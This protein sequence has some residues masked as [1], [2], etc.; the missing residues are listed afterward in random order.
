MS[1]IEFIKQF[2]NHK[3]EFTNVTLEWFWEEE[4]ID[5]EYCF[6][7]NPVEFMA[8]Y[9]RDYDCLKNI[10]IF[11]V[12]EMEIKNDGLYCEIYIKIVEE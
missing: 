8:K 12:K 2:V 11:D 5:E 7:G 3:N 10:D 1:L 6:E 9:T 4:G